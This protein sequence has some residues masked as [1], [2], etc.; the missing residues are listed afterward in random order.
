MRSKA[1]GQPQCCHW[2][3]FQYQ[4]LEGAVR[5]E[6][7]AGTNDREYQFSS[8]VV[9]VVDGMGDCPRFP[10]CPAFPPPQFSRFRIGVAIARYLLSWFFSCLPAQ[11]QVWW[12]RFGFCSLRLPTG[13][14]GRCSASPVFRPVHHAFCPAHSPPIQQIIVGSS[15]R[16][17]GPEDS[18]HI[19]RCFRRLCGSG[20]GHGRCH[21]H[22][23][24]GS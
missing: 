14:A 9:P 1:L 22:H 24:C 7:I 2:P 4:H 3:T 18:G 12:R 8:F 13:P 6:G 16:E 10:P 17:S 20:T 21:Q 11:Q 15:D 19:P 5:A 23:S